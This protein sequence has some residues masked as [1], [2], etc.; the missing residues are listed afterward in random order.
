LTIVP[1]WP[2]LRADA[3]LE[4]GDAIHSRY[5]RIARHLVR[6]AQEKETPN[7]KRLREYRESALDSLRSQ[8]FSPAPIYPELE[9]VKLAGPLALLAQ[10]LGGEHPLVVKVLAGTSPEARPAE[11]TA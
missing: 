7:E 11:L 4:L 5:F 3:L 10:N 9:R 6:L 1:G 8:L 2:G